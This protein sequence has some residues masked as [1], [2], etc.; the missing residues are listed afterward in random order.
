MIFFV[1]LCLCSFICILFGVSHFDVHLLK[2]RKILSSET[3]DTTRKTNDLSSCQSLKWQ[4]V[5]TNCNLPIYTC[6]FSNG[7]FEKRKLIDLY[8]NIPKVLHI[9]WFSREK[10]LG[11]F[12]WSCSRL[13]N[14]LRK[15][16]GEK[17]NLGEYFQSYSET[18][19][20]FYTYKFIE[21][22]WLKWKK[23]NGL[24]WIN[25]DHFWNVRCVSKSTTKMWTYIFKKLLLS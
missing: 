12:V 10:M 18:N 6:H 15:W 3:A 5:L 24:G 4:V 11:T 1:C 8:Y 21:E 17:W 7:L 14:A 13:Q 23:G 16:N 22:Y 25:L 19:F 2:T 9:R 20:F